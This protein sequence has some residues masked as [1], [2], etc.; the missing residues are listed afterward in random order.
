MKG[1]G[2]L[3]GKKK[4]KQQQEQQQDNSANTNGSSSSSSA[5]APPP[6]FNGPNDFMDMT[7][8]VTSFSTSALP[9]SLF[10]APEGYTKVQPSMDQLLGNARSKQ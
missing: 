4:Q 8:E 7:V 3:F 5:S 6:G 2:G 1:L 10:Q 9:D